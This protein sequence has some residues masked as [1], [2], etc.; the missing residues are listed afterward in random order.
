MYL[1]RK[2]CELCKFA[3]WQADFTTAQWERSHPKSV[4][5]EC[6]Q[7]QRL[8][9]LPM[10]CTACEEWK[11]EAGFNIANRN[12]RNTNT[13]VCLQCVETRLCTGPCKKWLPEDKFTENQWWRANRAKLQGKC[14]ECMPQKNKCERVNNVT[15]ENL[16]TSFRPG[17]LKTEQR[18]IK[19][20]MTAWSP[21]TRNRNGV[22]GHVGS[23]VIEN[24]AMEILRSG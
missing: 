5:K 12:Y 19:S 23:V 7:A 1:P 18:A 24:N 22:I 2:Q 14:K 4:C 16:K 8:A 20:V 13:R 21:T 9:G 10:Q 6:V 11:T 17:R 15:L 3:K